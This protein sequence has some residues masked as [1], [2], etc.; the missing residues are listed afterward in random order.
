MPDEMNRELSRGEAEEVE[1]RS[2]PEPRIVHAAIV[3]QGG[4]E[5]ARPVRSLLWSGVGAGFAIS[6]SLVGQAA[7]SRGLPDAPWR[8]TLTAFGYALGFLVVILG[9]MQ[10]FTEQT[11][12]AV[13]PLAKQPSLERLARVARLWVIVFVGNL[14]GAAAVTAL[15]VYG[16]TQSPDLQQGMVEISMKL[17]DRGALD[18]LLQAIP[19]GFLIASIAWIRSASDDGSVWIILF[20]TWAIG[21]GGF[22][23]VVAGACE[24][25]LLMWSGHAGLAWVATGFV[26]PALAG[27]II[28]GTG[29]FALLIHAQVKE[30]V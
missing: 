15:I 18:T 9:R 4:D 3:K 1:Q 29:L 14:L 19:A 27:N 8:E 12:V 30:E 28:G 6:S 16:R 11:M 13:L 2:A 21:A 26:L 23:H 24:A 5:L 22:A 20:I 7:I 17:L 10:L 25:F